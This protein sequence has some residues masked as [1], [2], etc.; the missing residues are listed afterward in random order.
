MFN[1]IVN[2]YVMTLSVLGKT[3]TTDG[4]LP[5]LALSSGSGNPAWF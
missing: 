3:L 1:F 2:F 4:M 5:S